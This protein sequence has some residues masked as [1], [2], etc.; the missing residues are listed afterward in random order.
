[1]NEQHCAQVIPLRAIPDQTGPVITRAQAKAKRLDRFFTGTPCRHGHL[2][3]RYVS[4]TTCIACSVQHAAAWQRAH[5][6]AGWLQH[7]MDNGKQRAA[8]RGVPFALA[9]DYL[10]TLM[11]DTCPALGCQLVYRNPGAPAW[12]SATVDRIIPSEGYVPGNVVVI[13]H[14][15]NAIKQNATADQILAVGSWL[16]EIEEPRVCA[17]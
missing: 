16:K 10:K 5:P 8:K 6:E 7:A 11:V 13:S 14:L 1:V 9:K 12:N 17:A 4:N 2:A 15:A 3:Q